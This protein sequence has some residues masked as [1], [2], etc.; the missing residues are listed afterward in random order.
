MGNCEQGSSYL[1]CE[2][3]LQDLKRLR[4]LSVKV[5]NGRYG[6][7]KVWRGCGRCDKTEAFKGLQRDVMRQ[8]GL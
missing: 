1:I 3:P 2:E 7:T 6:E 5:T 8:K 4:D